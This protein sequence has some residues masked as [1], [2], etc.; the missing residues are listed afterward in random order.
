M[1]TCPFWAGVAGRLRCVASRILLDAVSL[2]KAS[3]HERIV[4]YKTDR[5]PY[6]FC[7]KKRA[8][9]WI[10]VIKLSGEN[11]IFPLAYQTSTS[12]R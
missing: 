4:S 9:S 12:F 10:N 6:C 1:Q 3:I 2:C 7:Q 11:F 8:I 5:K